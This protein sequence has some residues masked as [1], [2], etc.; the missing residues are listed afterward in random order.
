MLGW[1]KQYINPNEKELTRQRFRYIPGNMVETEIEKEKEYICYYNALQ[2]Q[3]VLDT[4][5]CKTELAAWEKETTHSAEFTCSKVLNKPSEPGSYTGFYTIMD[6]ISLPKPAKDLD[7]AMEY[8]GWGHLTSG[9]LSVTGGE[10]SYGVFGQLSGA[11]VKPIYGITGDFRAMT[12]DAAQCVGEKYMMVTVLP[13][14]N[15]AW[16]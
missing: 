12:T 2:K 15:S 1:L 16:S 11:S 9:M 7:P 14:V 3:F 4:G 10:K 13:A 5:I 6:N 8:G